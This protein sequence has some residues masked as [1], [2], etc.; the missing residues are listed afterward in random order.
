MI[1]YRISVE[2][3]QRYLSI[4]GGGSGESPQIKREGEIAHKSK[5]EREREREAIR[6]KREERRSFQSCTLMRRSMK[7][8]IRAERR[9][10][11]NAHTS[12]LRGKGCLRCN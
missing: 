1:H 6:D 3:V 7:P 4:G 10:L 8:L 12:A 5:R 11:E 2:E 9:R